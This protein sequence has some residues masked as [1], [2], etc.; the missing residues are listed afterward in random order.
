MHN[1]SSDWPRSPRAVRAR[2]FRVI[3]DTD[4][5]T[6]V[7]DAYALALLASEPSVVLHGVT[8]V[9]GDTLFRARLTVRM[10]GL[11][12]RSSRVFA[13]EG[14]PLSG[15]EVW[16]SGAEGV[17]YDGLENEVTN[18][19]TSGVGFLL[20]ETRKFP[21]EIDIVAIGPLTNIAMAIQRDS[22]FAGRVRRLW[23]MGG[24]FDGASE[25]E[26]NFRSDPLAA[27]IVFAA[28]IP[29]TV[30]GVDATRAVHL[31][32]SEL[33]ELGRSGP[34]GECLERDTRH[35]MARWR[36]DFEVPHDAVVALAL[37]RPDLYECKRATV[38]VT[39]AGE[40]AGAVTVTTPLG[41]GGEAVASR[42]VEVVVGLRNQLVA[43]E[44]LGRVCR[45]SVRGREHLAHEA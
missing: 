31:E 8:T 35:W 32:G 43:E 29:I 38:S 11:M 37:V 39:P 4:I 7:D 25:I 23:V 24:R 9:Y 5:G 19:E 16:L 17:G 45:A 28:G 41:V 15:D 14:L 2:T 12:G 18:C 30:A 34:F 26:H 13:G 42:D 20:E 21:G 27:H 10:L 36:E 22:D 3:L 1:P 44:I 40:R 33:T 6:D